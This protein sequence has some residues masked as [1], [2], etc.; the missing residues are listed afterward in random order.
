MHVAA[1]DRTSTLT[2]TIRKWLEGE[3]Y[4]ECTMA[5]LEP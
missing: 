3:T 5:T 1:V 2:V 4:A